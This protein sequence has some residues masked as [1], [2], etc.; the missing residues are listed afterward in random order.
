MRILSPIP[1]KYT[2][3]TGKTGMIGKTGE[4]GKT[5]MTHMNGGGGG[6]ER[7]RWGWP[8]RGLETDY[9]ISG[10]IRGLE[11]NI[12]KGQHTTYNI[13]HTYIRRTWQLID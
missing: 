8:M 6:R 4:T 3:L 7:E 2:K 1:S 13:H 5:G 11:K 9:L 10:P 12:G